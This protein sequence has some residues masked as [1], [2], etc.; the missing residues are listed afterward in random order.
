VKG[1]N[2]NLPTAA[3]IPRVVLLSR[4]KYHKTEWNDFWQGSTNYRASS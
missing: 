4:L 3:K 1:K 2:T